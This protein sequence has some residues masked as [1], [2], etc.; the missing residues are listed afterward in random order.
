MIVLFIIVANAVAVQCI[1]Y[2]CFLFRKE[3][4]LLIPLELVFEFRGFIKIY[5]RKDKEKWNL[6]LDLCFAQFVRGLRISRKMVIRFGIAQLAGTLVKGDKLWH[7][8]VCF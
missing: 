6:L 4:L 2:D 1:G 3:A 5:K 8:Q 7:S